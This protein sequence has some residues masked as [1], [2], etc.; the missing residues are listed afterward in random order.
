VS[1]GEK[2]PKVSGLAGGSPAANAGLRVGDKIYSVDG[3]PVETVAE[4]DRELAKKTAPG[5]VLLKA[6][7]TRYEAREVRVTVK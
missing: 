7:P 2:A 3:R 4:F 1:V 5:E 6:G